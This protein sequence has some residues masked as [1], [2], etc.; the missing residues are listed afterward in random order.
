MSRLDR[1]QRSHGSHH[2]TKGQ[3]LLSRP[4]TQQPLISPCLECLRISA[5][6]EDR[7]AWRA[8]ASRDAYRKFGVKDRHIM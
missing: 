8:G 6:G 2:L 3:G 7:E 4:N 5:G 1:Q